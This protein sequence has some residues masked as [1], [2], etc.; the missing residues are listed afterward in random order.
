MGSQRVRHNRVTEQQLKHQKK[1]REKIGKKNIFLK[2]EWL[3]FFQLKWQCIPPE[4]LTC[5]ETKVLLYEYS[6]AKMATKAL[7]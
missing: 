6:V 4:S 5:Y 3:K 2:K 1:N 7:S